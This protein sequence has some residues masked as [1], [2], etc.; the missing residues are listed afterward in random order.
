MVKDPHTQ[1]PIEHL[2]NRTSVTFFQ[3]DNIMLL[4]LNAKSGNTIFL[5]ENI[6]STKVQKNTLSP[7]EIFVLPSAS[8]AERAPIPIDGKTVF[9]KK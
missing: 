3:P 5:K 1:I 7:E 2:Y 8:L 9:H 6:D 4:N